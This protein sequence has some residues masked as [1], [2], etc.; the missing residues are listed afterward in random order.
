MYLLLASIQVIRSLS[1][2]VDLGFFLE[3][4]AYWERQNWSV[5]PARA[6]IKGS[7]WR[8]LGFCFLFFVLWG[9][10]SCGIRGSGLSKW[11][12][13]THSFPA[14]LVCWERA[15]DALTRVPYD[16]S[17]T[18]KSVRQTLSYLQFCELAYSWG[19]LQTLRSKYWGNRLYLETRFHTDPGAAEGLDWMVRD[20]SISSF[21]VLGLHVCVTIPGFLSGCL[22]Y[23]L[24]SSGLCGKHLTDWAPPQLPLEQPET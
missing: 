5:L 13:N 4:E 15:Q 20:P 24:R 2:R 8:V 7:L 9:R 12:K 1:C 22:G 6:Q 17:T 18:S 3:D 16:I 11:G 23:K 21:P 10:G 19:H 14:V